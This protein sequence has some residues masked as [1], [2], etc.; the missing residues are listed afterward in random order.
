MYS[1]PSRPWPRRGN[2]P[3]A[4]AKL[5]DAGG[6]SNRGLIATSSGCGGW[7]RMSIMHR[8]ISTTTNSSSSMNGSNISNRPARRITCR[9]CGTHHCSAA[10]ASAA[11]DRDAFTVVC[12]S[13]KTCCQQLHTR[14]YRRGCASCSLSCKETCVA[15]TSSR[16]LAVW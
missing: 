5:R 1:A 15:W 16:C 6:H 8:S 4:G 11:T 9:G 14:A 12:S 7:Q 13:M 2:R 3:G 10:T